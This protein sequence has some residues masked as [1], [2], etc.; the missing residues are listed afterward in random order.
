MM[1]ISEIKELKRQYGFTNED[2]AKMSTVP[3]STV[4]KIM[5]GEVKSPRYDTLEKLSGALM[6]VGTQAGWDSKT[7]SSVVCE[8]NLAYSADDSYGQRR[9]K[10]II[11][12]METKKQGEY[13][14]EDY[15]ALPDEHR[16]ELIDGVL[17]DM[18]TPLIIH[19]E[20]VQDSP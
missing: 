5:S 12:E 16:A 20:A 3:L 8:D 4:Q 6:A 1:K 14:L 9:R 13:T 18:A 10:V 17:Y 2:L 7:G 15:Y 19:Q 11:K